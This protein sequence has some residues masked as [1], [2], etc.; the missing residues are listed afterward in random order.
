MST[1]TILWTDLHANVKAGVDPG[2]GFQICSPGQLWEEL[3]AGCGVSAS[4][5]FRGIDFLGDLPAWSFQIFPQHLTFNL[6][7]S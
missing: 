7:P 6:P 1:Q 4:P 2:S 5:E 3:N